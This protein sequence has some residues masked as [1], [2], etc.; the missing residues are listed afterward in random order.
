MTNGNLD[1]FFNNLE[2]PR[3]YKNQKHPFLSLIY[4]GLL[5]AIAGIDSFSGLADYAEAHKDE[6]KNF[7][8]LPN[9]PPSH[10]IPC[11]DFLKILA[12]INFMIV[13]WSLLLS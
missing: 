13:L 9:G 3:S 11:K 2:D 12:A 4:I 8:E 5:G 7:I 10:E 1:K 6:L